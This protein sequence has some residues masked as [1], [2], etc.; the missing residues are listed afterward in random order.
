MER[1]EKS[2]EEQWDESSVTRAAIVIAA[3]AGYTKAIRSEAL[4]CSAL[5]RCHEKGDRVLTFR[6]AETNTSTRSQ[7]GKRRRPKR[8][9]ALRLKWTRLGDIVPQMRMSCG[10]NKNGALILVQDW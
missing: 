7:A 9:T 3:R 1:C 8:W 10:R 4:L 5:L 2:R 6:F